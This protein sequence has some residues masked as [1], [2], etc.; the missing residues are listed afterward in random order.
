MKQLIVNMKSFICAV[1]EDTELNFFL[2]QK[3]KDT[4]LSDTFQV[5]L[6]SRGMPVDTRLVNNLKTCFKVTQQLLL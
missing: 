3:S 6:T 1:G 2:Y 4:V 5:N